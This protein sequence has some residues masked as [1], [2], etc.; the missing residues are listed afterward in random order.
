MREDEVRLSVA[1][2]T[3]NRPASLRRALESVREQDQQPYE[4]VVSDDS[5]EKYRGA[6]K[7]VVDGFDMRYLAGPRRGLYANR[8]HAA[9]ACRGSHIR[10]MDD[11][12]EWPPGHLSCCLEA[13]REDCRAIWVIGEAWPRELAAGGDAMSCLHPPLQVNARGY[14]ERAPDFGSHAIADGSTIFP[15]SIFDRERYFE[16]FVFGSSYLEFGDRLNWLGYT[17]RFLDGTYVLHHWGEMPRSYAMEREEIGS[18][19]FAALCHSWLYSESTLDRVVTTVELFW[20][21]LTKGRV[22]LSGVRKAI[23]AFAGRSRQLS[24][25]VSSGIT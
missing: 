4:V 3:R 21:V 10:T 18:R 13:I 9:L 12:H 15:S 20:T 22:G 17:I 23:G 11:D 2:V 25:S 14:S 6:V 16:G 5:D 8:N 7:D 1:L 19:V 24:D